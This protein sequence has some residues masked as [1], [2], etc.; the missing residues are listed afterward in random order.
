MFAITVLFQFV[1]IVSFLK[2][3]RVNSDHV[4]V[5][6]RTRTLVERVEQDEGK[7]ISRREGPSSL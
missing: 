3:S 2:T 1:F 4:N 7:E 6:I 5:S